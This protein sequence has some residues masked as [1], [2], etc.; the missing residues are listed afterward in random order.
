MP[1]PS[2]PEAERYVLFSSVLRAIETM[3][4]EAPVILALDDVQWADQASMNLL[5]HL[6]TMG[7]TMRILV[8]ASYRADESMH[9]G[10][11]TRVIGTFRQHSKCT[12][13]ALRGFSPTEVSS[14][15]SMA[16][17]TGIDS[18]ESLSEALYAETDGN[19]LF[20]TEVVRQLVNRPNMHDANS[21]VGEA[22]AILPASLADVIGSRVHRLGQS[23]P[24]ILSTASVFGQSFEVD[25][26]AQAAGRSY[27]EVLDVLEA[28]V[29]VFLV[30]ETVDAIGRF[31]FTHLLIRR[32]LYEKLGATRRAGIHGH[33]AQTLEDRGE[34]S[35][36]TKAAE[37]AAHWAQSGSKEGRFKA[38]AYFQRAGD[39]ALDRLAPADAARY[40]QRALELNNE[41]VDPDPLATLDLKIGIGVARRQIGEP[42]S[43][44]SLLEAAQEALALGDGERL[45]RAVLEN[46]RGFFSAFG[47]LDGEKVAMLKAALEYS[48]KNSAQR[49]MV[50]ATYCQELAF[51]S[52]LERRQ[53]LAEEALSTARASGDATTVVRVL[54][55]VDAPLRVPQELQRS[56]IRS[57]EALE[58]AEAIG[59]PVLLFWAAASRKASAAQAGD[60]AEVDRCMRI[61]E[62][63]A[64]FRRPT[65]DAV[66]T[67]LCHG[68]PSIAGRRAGQ[69]RTDCLSGFRNRDER[70]R[71]RCLRCVGLAVDVDQFAA[72]VD[73]GDGPPH[74]TSAHQQPSASGLLV[75]VGRR[76]R[77]G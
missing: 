68:H 58:G 47:Q 33:I 57:A 71:A 50:L 74:R 5:L 21:V 61:A 13:T 3:C 28:A 62:G 16:L 45:I 2:D 41:H 34:A 43:R 49:A 7:S 8:I 31:E 37:L 24:E 73:G 4:G 60:F 22:A 19:P 25:L 1:F 38:I 63:L 64:T 26:L 10:D 65:H 44:R 52:P 76:P 23:G 59:D 11:G 53:L 32:I 18:N 15:L 30:K 20:V 17:T 66:D 67:H 54:N 42:G 39:D 35:D 70:R 27:L 55:R 56:L 29:R 12:E 36:A 69:G 40:Y 9:G 14:F 6:I 72:W 77:R 48:H 75:G 46:D 51:D